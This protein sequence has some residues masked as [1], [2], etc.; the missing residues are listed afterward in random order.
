MAR[1]IS[2][3]KRKR[4]RVL[5]NSEKAKVKIGEK[6]KKAQNNEE[7]EAGK[8]KK[9]L[10]GPLRRRESRLARMTWKCGQGGGA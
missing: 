10:V 2:S 8:K 5:A 3:K 4:D 1:K 9:R 7:E 6:K